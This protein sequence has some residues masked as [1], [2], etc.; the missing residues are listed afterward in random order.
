MREDVYEEELAAMV[1]RKGN[2]A[3]RDNET[4]EQ[5]VTKNTKG[6]KGG[7][8]E[9]KERKREEKT[10]WVRVMLTSKKRNIVGK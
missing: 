1:T 10:E 3:T 5:K 9:S 8:R 7:I 6:M 4:Q 2:R